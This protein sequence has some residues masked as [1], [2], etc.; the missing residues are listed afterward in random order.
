MPSVVRLGKSACGSVGA[1]P[2]SRGWKCAWGVV[3]GLITLSTIVN[4]A[5]GDNPLTARFVEEIQPILIDHCY[6]CHADGQK[7]GN[8]GLD[9]FTTDAALTANRDLW[10]AVL[11][12]VRSGMMPPAGRP[13]LSTDEIGRLAAWIK[14]DILALDPRNPDPGRVTIRRLNRVEYRNT[15]RDLMGIEFKTEEEFP[16]DDTGYGFDT[17]GDVLTVSPML[18]EKYLQAAETIVASAVPTTPRSMPEKKFRGIDFS[19]TDGG[20][21]GDRVPLN[22]QATL[23][24]KIQIDHAGE[25]RF[26][27]EFLLSARGA[28]EPVQGTF[29]LKIDDREPVSA[30]LAVPPFQAV[31][32]DFTVSLTQGEHRL[33]FEIRP[34]V[35][36][37]AAIVTAEAKPTTPD[38]KR[39][40]PEPKPTKPAAAGTDLGKADSKSK[41]APIKDS[42]PKKDAPKPPEIRIVMLR[43]QGPTEPK[44]WEPTANYARFFPR[45]E[46]PP[47]AAVEDRRGYAGE[48]LG[49][50]A[51]RAF[52]RPA[53][54]ATVNRLVSIAE[55]VYTQPGKRFEDGV[56][57]AMVAVLAA[58]RFLFRVEDVE[59]T[60]SGEAYPLVDEFAL[61]S[62]LS[63]FLWSTMPDGEL[64]ALAGKGELRKNLASQVKR[65]RADPRSEALTR[66]FVGQWL[67]VRDVEGM[68]LNERVILK[69]EGVR[70]SSAF[71]TILGRELTRAIHRE[72]DMLFSYVLNEDR[73][74]ME[75]VDS[76]YTF[77][78]ARL[79][80]HYGIKDVSGSEMK[81]VSLAKDS[82]RGGILTQAATLMVTSN[83]TRTSPVKRGKFILDNI[84][85]TPPPP[86]PPDIPA[87]EDAKKDFK[88]REPSTREMMVI[89]RSKAICSSCHSRMDPLGLALENFNALGMWRD[90]ELDQS[91]D[92][93]GQLITGESFRDI[94]ELKHLLRDKHRTD[95]YRCLSEKLLTYALGRGLEATDVETV[96]QIV[97]RLERQGGHSSALLMGVIESAPFQKRRAVS[98]AT[99]DANGSSQSRADARSKP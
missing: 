9:Q 89:H 28:T 50:F 47:A 40:K 99:N 92:P 96:D 30:S 68:F 83:P 48:I 61:A 46:P 86:P 71:N 41:K 19:N 26:F 66:N 79:A 82:P 57:R 74:V 34:V 6:R 85:G 97:Q 72:T 81:R 98:V 43:M 62:R 77:L 67:E 54:D 76:D 4:D 42:E 31:R 44:F 16:P 94:R 58:P 88:G 37:V 93:A 63:Y 15:I 21:Y 84:L 56:A 65:M 36:Q 49:R 52:R 32:R 2:P 12:N 53:A 27:L 78:N 25:Y 17:I 14:S 80:K 5:R 60:T 33:A 11:R 91:V 13:R 64:V 59:A 24:R 45:A 23:T 55:S 51:N 22:K 38:P 29:T 20:G 87:L 7:K 75:L 3:L 69:R 8:I 95:F 70:T 10:W 39:A 35:K 73:D 18:L 90:K 1:T